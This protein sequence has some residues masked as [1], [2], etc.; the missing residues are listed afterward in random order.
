MTKEQYRA[1]ALRFTA[2]RLLDDPD[3]W[4]W[5]EVEFG[6]QDWDPEKLLAALTPEVKE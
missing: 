5:F 1:A 4:E 6:D 3:N 2:D